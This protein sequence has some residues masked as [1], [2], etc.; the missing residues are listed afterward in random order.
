MTNNNFIQKIVESSKRIVIENTKKFSIKKQKQ[1][2]KDKNKLN[3]N[4]ELQQI[5]EFLREFIDEFQNDNFK[6]I[7]YIKTQNIRDCI[8]FF[9]I[10]R[11]KTKNENLFETS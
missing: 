10:L 2:S 8:V 6:A 7:I 11:E 4:Q 5:V 3:S 1:K 9:F